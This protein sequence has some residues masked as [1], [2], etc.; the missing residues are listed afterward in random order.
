MRPSQVLNQVFQPNI[1]TFIHNGLN[2]NI[3]GAYS[4]TVIEYGA[5][6]RSWLERSAGDRVVLGSNPAAATSL[7]NFGNSIY[8]ALPVDVSI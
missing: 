3:I 4:S 5:R 1:E 6:W 2:I 7:R 8:P